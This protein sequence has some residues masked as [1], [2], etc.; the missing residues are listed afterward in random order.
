[1]KQYIVI[2]PCK[3]E[4]EN[5]PDLV[6]SLIK[7]S[8]T[9]AL[10]TIVND[11]STDKT[12][13]IINEIKKEYKW[14]QSIFLE[15]SPRDLTIHISK[16]EKIGFDFAINYCNEH[17]INYDFIVFLDADM[18]IHDIEFIEKL[19]IEFKKD[20][21]LGIASGNIQIMD[22]SGNLVGGKGRSDTISGGEMICRRECVEDFAGVPLTYAWDSVMRVKAILKGWKIKRF[23]EIKIIQ[24]RETSSAKGLKKGY[25]IRGTGDYYLNFNPAVVIGKAMGYC[26]KKPYYIGIAYFFGYFSSF[27]LRKE[28]VNDRAIKRYFYWDKTL[29]ILEYY[30]KIFKTW[31]ASKR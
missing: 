3:N 16:I 22:I 26:L 17:N 28:Q 25:Y 30:I 5:L 21:H 18:I 6:Q 12:P 2:T 24:S 7:Q 19:I 8:I 13:E 14:I 10:W 15:E 29:E 23:H 20:E 9:P 31:R 11:G 1:M 4:E 27:M